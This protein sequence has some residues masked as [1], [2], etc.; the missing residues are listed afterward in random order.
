M[1]G[2]VFGDGWVY[3]GTPH[4]RDGLQTTGAAEAGYVVAVQL[5]DADGVVV[6]TTSSVGEYGFYSFD[7]IAA[8]SYRVAFGLPT[9]SGMTYHFTTPNAGDDARDSD[10]DAAGATDL[11]TLAA[12]ATIDRDAGVYWVL[13]QQA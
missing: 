8:G 7:G 3:Y 1:S 4:D 11:F 5:L 9:G 2:R 6:A 10:A 13:D 12:G